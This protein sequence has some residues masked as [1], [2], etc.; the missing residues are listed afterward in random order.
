MGKKTNL[1]SRTKK[2]LREKNRQRQKATH[3]AKKTNEFE[4]VLTDLSGKQSG[5]QFGEEDKLHTGNKEETYPKV[6]TK[7]K[8]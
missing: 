7:A 1:S 4:N 2:N 3:Q 6:G 5:E 8:A